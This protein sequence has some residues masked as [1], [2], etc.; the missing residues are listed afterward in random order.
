IM[1]RDIKP[2]NCLI[3]AR[4]GVALGDF[5]LV[6]RQPGV[7]IQDVVCHDVC[8][9]PQYY[10]PELIRP[11]T[12]GYGYKADIW[13]LGCTLIEFLARLDQAWIDGFSQFYPDV[14]PLEYNEPPEHVQWL[15][16][17]SVQHLL[18]GHP[19]AM[20]LMKMVDLDPD[21]RPS[22]E[23]IKADPWFAGIDWDA[24]ERK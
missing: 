4:G 7:V 19:A 13:A 16:W 8:G 11:T 2:E 9:T 20:L 6:E 23:Q 12:A 1:H 10:A 24:I 18:P 21:A 22:T 14:N 5:G 15:L 17:W 3:D